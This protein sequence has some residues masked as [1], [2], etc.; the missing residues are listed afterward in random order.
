[1]KEWFLLFVISVLTV[2]NITMYSINK[3]KDRALRDVVQ[4]CTITAH[5]PNLL[6]LPPTRIEAWPAKDAVEL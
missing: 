1:M 3:E 5:D 6:Q 2:A 4:H